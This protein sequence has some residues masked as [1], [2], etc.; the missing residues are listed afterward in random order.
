[1]KVNIQE[2]YEK[3]IDNGEKRTFFKDLNLSCQK[4]ENQKLL[5]VDFIDCDLTCTIFINC[6]LRGSNFEKTKMNN[7]KFINCHIL[8]CEFPPQKEQMSFH[9]CYNE[10]IYQPEHQNGPVRLGFFD[11]II[12]LITSFSGVK[13]EKILAIAILVIAISFLL[14]I[15]KA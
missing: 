3:S 4:I 8:C 13:T 7:T 15:Y 2:L 14:A 11:N 6:D 5:C 9:N 10:S 1:M 12:K